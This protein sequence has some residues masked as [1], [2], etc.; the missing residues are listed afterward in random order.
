MTPGH[1]DLWFL[2]LG[3]TGEIG[4]NLN[5]YGHDERW[6][7]VDCGIT[8]A[9]DGEP[10]PRVQMPDPRFIEERREQLSALLITHAHQDHVGAV[11][12]LWPRLRCPVYATA[13]TLALLR[14]KLA[15][16]GLLERVPLH[17]VKPGLRHRIDGFD[18]EWLPI[19]HSTPE[20][21]ALVIRTAVG[22]VLHTGDWKLDHDPVV[23]PAC[24]APDFQKLADENLLAMICD[25]TNADV[26][27]RSTSEGTLHA[28][29]REAVAA[30]TGRVVVGCFGSNIARLKTLASVARACGRYP[31]LLGRSLH[32]YYGAAMSAGLWPANLRYV[33]AEDLGYLPP[34]EVLAVATGSQGESRAALDRLAADQHPAFGLDA[35]DTVILSSRVIPGNELQVSAMIERL[36]GLG[37]R[38]VQDISSD[39]PIH[40]SGHPPQE[41]LKDL[42]R[43]VA[44]RTAIPVHGEPQHLKAHAAVAREV[45]IGKRMVGRNGDLYLLAPQRAI[46]RGAVAAGRLGVEREQLVTVRIDETRR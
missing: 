30:S 24:H 44:P 21:Q 35:G 40:A 22:G 2:P 16:A 43:W 25:S 10:G 20:S 11:A 14:P 18:I 33:A 4:M 6:L 17:E 13:F 8:F 46:R 39:R 36:E 3:G 27:G 15:R 19:T 5:L 28:G 41:D 12:H 23:G 34:R 7:M 38:V 42:Y 45:G 26:A 29:L 1:E 9:R 32:D 37:V 31:A